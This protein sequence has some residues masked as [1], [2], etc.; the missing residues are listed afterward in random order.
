MKTYRI[1]GEYIQRVYIDIPAHD[2]EEA[3]DIAACDTPNDQWTLIDT[4][5]VVIDITEVEYA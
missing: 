1:Y 5:N 4:P 2:S 3:Q